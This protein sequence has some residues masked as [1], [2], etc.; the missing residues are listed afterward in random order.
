MRTRIFAVTVII[1]VIVTLVSVV[2]WFVWKPENN[3]I[4]GEISA[5]SYKVSSQMPG[6]IDSLLVKRGQKVTKG[7]LVFVLHS[8][9]IDAKKQQVDALEDAAYAQNEKA[10]AGARKQQ[11]DQAYQQYTNA[12]IQEEIYSKTYARVKAL[13]EDGVVSA[14]KYDEVKAKYDAACNT[15]IMAKDQ[16]DMALEGARIEDKKAARAL[17]D[18]AKGGVNEVESYLNDAHQ[19]APVDGEVSSVVNQEGE[20]VGAGMPIVT[21]IDLNNSWAVFNIKETLLSKFKI[22]KKIKTYVPALD[23]NVDMEITYIAPLASYAT[24]TATSASGEFDIKTFEVQAKPVQ[25]DMQDIR[26]G[27]SVLIDKNSL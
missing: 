2:A 12:K 16:Y 20:L 5:N 7:Q 24:W 17:V 14:Q 22:G 3:Y 4:Q 15:T 21:I 25:A 9:T 26:L 18:Q 11:I 19:Y 6:R 23:K 27:M 13:Y 10:L 8:E 1:L